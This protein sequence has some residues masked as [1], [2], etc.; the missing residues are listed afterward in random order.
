M[1]NEYKDWIEDLKNAPID[2]N[3]HKRWLLIEY[4][5]LRMEEDEVINYFDIEEVKI[6][7]Y[8]DCA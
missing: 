6:Y 3:D 5:W 4:P 2:S 1:S 8:I 7:T